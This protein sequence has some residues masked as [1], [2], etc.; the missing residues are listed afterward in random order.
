MLQEVSIEVPPTPLRVGADERF[1][2][3]GVTIALADLAAGRGLIESF[4]PAR[5]R[6]ALHVSN[7]AWNYLRTRLR[8]PLCRFNDPVVLL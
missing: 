4:S 1:T 6:E 2:G 5:F 7:H 3:R 8:R